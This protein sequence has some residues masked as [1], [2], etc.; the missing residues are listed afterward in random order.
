MQELA[1]WLAWELYSK[2]MLLMGEFRLSSGGYSSYYF[3]LRRMYSYPETYRRI[4]KEFA[5]KVCSPKCPDMV[6]GVA[7]A[8][9]PLAAMV[10]YTRSLPMGYVRI[11]RK[12]HGGGRLIEGLVKGREIVVI[13]DVATTG[14]SIAE[15]VESIRKEGGIVERAAVIIDREE[16]ASR[17]L[18]EMGV[19]LVSLVKASVLFENLRRRGIRVPS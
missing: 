5:Y 11:R 4:V 18:A 19:E 10:A 15:A 3:D 2:S 6:M 1:E 16:G 14:K 8:G 12:T 13:D 17:T 9:I 7:T